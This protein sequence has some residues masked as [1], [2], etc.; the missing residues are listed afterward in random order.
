MR[1]FA[2][3]LERSERSPIIKGDDLSASIAALTRNI[4][5]S[6][7]SVDAVIK[8]ASAISGGNVA[9]GTVGEIHKLPYG[10]DLFY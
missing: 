5:I 9:V 8:A 7:S 6:V 1:P 3:P 2:S 4:D 10:S